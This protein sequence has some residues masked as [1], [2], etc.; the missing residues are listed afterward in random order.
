[1]SSIRIGLIIAAVFFAG[2]ANASSG[3]P[4]GNGSVTF[5]GGAA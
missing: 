5:D 4:E 2:M 1:M 3:Q